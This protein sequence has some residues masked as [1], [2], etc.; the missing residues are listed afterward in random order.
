MT[1]FDIFVKLH[2]QTKPLLLP[3]AW[4]AAS[5]RI[6]EDLGATAIAT[7][8]AGVAWAQGYPD[9]G[10]MP[11][12]VNA[13][14]AQS[15]TRI[16]KVPLTVD[17]ENGYSNDPAVVAENIRL[18]LDAGVAGINL[19]DGNDGPDLLSKKIE[20]I[21]NAAEKQGSKLF[22]NARTDL[23]LAA[24]VAPDARV[25]EAIKRGTQYAAA[26]ADGLFVPA[27]TNPDEIAE[28]ANNIS[29]PLNVMAMPGLANANQ[30]AEL[31][32]KRLS[33]GTGVFSS[34]LQTAAKLAA[35]FLSDGDSSVFNEEGMSYGKLQQLFTPAT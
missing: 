32:V 16:I 6:F 29:L 9:G 13:R 10:K 26:G 23:Y 33:A 27:I 14:V 2:Q 8:S 24:L 15:I 31:G 12:A 11:A 28:I 20:A 30:L 3:N 5:A 1:S 21:K 25:K 22:V 34:A 19:E 7:T 35:A 4:D 18:L 17:F